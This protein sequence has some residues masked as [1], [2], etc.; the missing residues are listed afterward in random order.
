MPLLNRGFGLKLAL[1]LLV[2]AQMVSLAGCGGGGG[3]SDP[4]QST[5]LKQSSVSASNNPLVAQYSVT[6]S[7]QGT[8]AVEFGPTTSY[9]FQT[10]S[11]P[12]P[13]VGGT[14]NILIAGMKQNTL[15]H[16]RAVLTSSAGQVHD[17]DHTFQT[18]TIPPAQVPAMRVT[19]PAGQQPSAG[20]ELLSLVGVQPN[21]LTSLALNPTGD[22]IWYYNY[23]EATGV[24]SLTKLLPNGHMLMLLYIPGPPVSSAVR[25]VDL[26]GNVYRQFDQNELSQKLQAAGYN[27]QL[28][29]IDHDILLL[30]NGHLL[31]ITSD[32]RTFTDLPGYPGQT[33]VQG[34]AIIDV[35]QHNNPVWVWDAFDHLDVNRHPIYFPDWTHSNALFYSPDDGN[36]L[37]SVRHQHWVL[38]IDYQD[39]SG[40]GDILWKLGYQGDF[41]LDSNSPADWFYAQHDANIASP[42]TTGD[43]RM[44][45]FDNG[46]YRVL[47][48][49]GEVC[50]PK[51][52]PMCYS[53]AAIFHVNENNKTASREWSYQTPYSFWGGVTRELPNSNIFLTESAPADL[54]LHSSRVMEV[55]QQANPTVV[56]Q[57]EIDGQNSYRTIH[58][59]SLYPGVQW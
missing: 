44:A 2:S 4:P 15:Y 21:Q 52:P 42:N 32:S 11:Q 41:T 46:D 47:D 26:A 45:V 51:S 57:L 30:P 36:F 53:T 40:S 27:I 58:L 7:G 35:D 34:N 8:V 1:L 17:Q 33:F 22:I 23:D 39:G 12:L 24:P 3:V 14:V 31:F 54:G 5:Q 9:G 43:F 37:L 48:D 38:K 55:T 20:V 29:S 10:W 13:V 16:M 18:G 6:T 49:N 50:S 59:P 25:E 19:I 56:W 28:A